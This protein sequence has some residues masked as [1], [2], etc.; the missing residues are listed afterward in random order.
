MLLKVLG[1]RLKIQYNFFLDC[2]TSLVFQLKLPMDLWHV[3]LSSI[4][5][6]KLRDKNSG[7]FLPRADNHLEQEQ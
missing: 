2:S 4:S 7:L 6:Q 3:P 1:E 5:G